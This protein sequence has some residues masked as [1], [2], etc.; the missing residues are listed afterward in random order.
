MNQPLLDVPRV[1]INPRN[2]TESGFDFENVYENPERLFLEGDVDHVIGQLI[3]DTN[4][5][6]TKRVVL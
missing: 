5:G 6:V 2:T 3:K 4:L 1:L